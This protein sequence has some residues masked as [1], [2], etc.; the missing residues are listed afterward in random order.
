MGAFSDLKLS[1]WKVF[2]G[3]V[4]LRRPSR[5]RRPHGAPP[6]TQRY[7]DRTYIRQPYVDHAY[8]WVAT[9]ATLPGATVDQCGL[10]PVYLLPKT[11]CFFSD[12]LLNSEYHCIMIEHII[13]YFIQTLCAARFP[14]KQMYSSKYLSYH[15]HICEPST[16]P[17]SSIIHFKIRRGDRTSCLESLGRA[18]LLKA[19]TVH[20]EKPAQVT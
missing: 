6:L 11:Y 4:A 10:P 5:P 1:I 19:V 7:V 14:S 17:A 9:V 16:T 18:I 15:R 13:L 12:G 20:Q 2:A 8:L 3:Y